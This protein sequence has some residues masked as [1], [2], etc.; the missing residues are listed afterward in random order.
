MSE[1]KLGLEHVAMDMLSVWV[2]PTT[3]AVGYG[4]VGYSFA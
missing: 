4:S 3:S 1:G 2:D